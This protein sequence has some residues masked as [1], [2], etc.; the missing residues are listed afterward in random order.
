MYFLLK[1]GIFQPAMLVYRTVYIHK[2]HSANLAKERE[3][4]A[5]FTIRPQ[6]WCVG[7]YSA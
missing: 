2:N 4:V 5:D 3:I 7:K 6:P 1:M